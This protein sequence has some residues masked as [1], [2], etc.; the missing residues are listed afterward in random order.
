MVVAH[1]RWLHCSLDGAFDQVFVPVFMTSLP[2]L[3]DLLENTLPVFFFFW[4]IVIKGGISITM[5]KLVFFFKLLFDHNILQTYLLCTFL[6]S[7]SGDHFS[8]AT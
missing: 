8:H 5:R 7:N 3:F 2:K 1:G 4:H 6:F